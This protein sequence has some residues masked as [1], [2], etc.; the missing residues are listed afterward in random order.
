MILETFILFIGLLQPSYII[1]NIC[2]Q[3]Q[4][5]EELLADFLWCHSTHLVIAH[6]YFLEVQKW[7]IFWW[8]SLFYANLIFSKICLYFILV[9]KFAALIVLHFSSSNKYPQI[10]PHQTLPL[11]LK[12]LVP[13]FKISNKFSKSQMRPTENKK[14][15]FILFFNF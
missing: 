12:I 3:P 11:G 7:Y 8:K 14:Q 9:S 13:T 5:N 10:W 4:E 6:V 2:K 15:M 1:R